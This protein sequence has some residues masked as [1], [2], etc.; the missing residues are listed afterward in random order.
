MYFVILRRQI[1]RAALW[2]VLLGSSGFSS[3]LAMAEEVIPVIDLHV[4]LSYQ[5]NYKHRR[6]DRATGQLVAS[7][8]IESGVRGVVLPLYVP[9]EIAPKGPRMVDLE[10]SYQTMLSV[11]QR[12]LPYAPPGSPRQADRVATWFAF[13]GAAPFA[14]CPEEVKKW[15]E[16]GVRIWGLVHVHDN[17]LATSA[18]LGPKRL[19]HEVGL[20][21]AGHALVRAIHAQ[22]GIVDVSH[23]SDR[24]V[25]DI[26]EHARESGR[27][28]MA[29]H[30]NANRLAPH[31]RNLLD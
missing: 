2:L 20:T 12:T 21:E 3:S 9:H 25:A 23:A 1:G 11:V 5:V 17:A 14:D 22:G 4:D 19:S 15:V 28:V 27:P 31:A 29:T 30:S 16:R 26:L 7:R 18:G 10:S 24:A 13:E 6:P 8:L